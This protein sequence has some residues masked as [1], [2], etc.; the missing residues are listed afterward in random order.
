MDIEHAL[1]IPLVDARTVIVNQHHS[2]ASRGLV[3][4]VLNLHQDLLLDGA[5]IPQTGDL[6]RSV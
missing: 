6:L 4:D 1:E 3:P 2:P 5:Q